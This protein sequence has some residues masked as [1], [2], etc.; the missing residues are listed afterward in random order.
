MVFPSKATTPLS[1]NLA[2]ELTQFEKH[3]PNT[4]ESKIEK[5]SLIASCEGVLFLYG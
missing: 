5:R 1:F 2:I 3:F 4:F